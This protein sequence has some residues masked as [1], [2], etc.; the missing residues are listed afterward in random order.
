MVSEARLP[1]LTLQLYTEDLRDAER[2]CTVLKEVVRGLLTLLEPALKTNHVSLLPLHDAPER[3]VSGSFWKAGPKASVAAQNKRRNLIQDI[4]TALIRGHIVVFHVDGDD[5]YLEDGTHAEVWRHLDRLHHD[6]KRI[7]YDKAYVRTPLSQEVVLSHVF[8][9]VV[10][11]YSI[12]SWAYSN[13]E[14]LRET[15]VNIKDLKFLADW[16]RDPG[17][18]EDVRYIKR[19]TLSIGDEMNEDLVRVRS[20]FPRELLLGLK[21]S[22]ADT[23]RRFTDS[24]KLKAGLAEAASRPF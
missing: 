3:R 20:G 12:E 23:H 5:Q 8:L 16:S 13:T 2:E 22:Y 10:P 15:L 11:F 18:R 21:K 19:D 1:A 7:V 9:P 6:L 24:P 4:V 17:S 14:L